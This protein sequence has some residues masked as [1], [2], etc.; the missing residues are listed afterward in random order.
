MHQA[1]PDEPRIEEAADVP[2]E[3]LLVARAGGR[4]YALPLA[5]VHE[6]VPALPLTVVPG[7]G[8]AVSG[9]V[10]VRGRVVAVVG[11]ARAFGRAEAG[12][13]EERRLLVVEYRGRRVA[14]EVADV[15]RIERIPLDSLDLATREK[16]TGDRIRGRVSL[17]AGEVEILD[18]EQVLETVLG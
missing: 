12:P 3:S 11:L 18:A 8:E 14:I 16:A 15:V 6:V 10:N 17:E 7:A 13:A 9:M 4:L 5:Q 2:T 1:P